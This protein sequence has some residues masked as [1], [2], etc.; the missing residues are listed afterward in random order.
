ME[1]KKESHI[2]KNLRRLQILVPSR[3]AFGPISV[4]GWTYLGKGMPHKT[5]FRTT[6]LQ[7]SNDCGVKTAINKSNFPILK[8][9]AIYRLTLNPECFREPHWQAIDARVTMPWQ[10]RAELRIKLFSSF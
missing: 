6:Q 9:L 10:S 1:R 4:R 3:Q 8:R 7:I 2:G 5:S